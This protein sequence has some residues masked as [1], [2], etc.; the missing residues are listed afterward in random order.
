M[1]KYIFMK[2]RL[3]LSS[4]SHM[5]K[6]H[7]AWIEPQVNSNMLA[8]PQ[9]ISSF[10]AFLYSRYVILY[11]FEC[12]QTPSQTHTGI[13]YIESNEIMNTLHQTQSNSDYKMLSVDV[14][15]AL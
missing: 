7:S 9:K 3:Q 6:F 13:K 5:M 15:M 4:D 1:C 2:S 12:F 8:E 10:S 11:R 14:S